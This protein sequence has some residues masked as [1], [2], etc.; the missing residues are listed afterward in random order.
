M[1]N[2]G[3]MSRDTHEWLSSLAQSGAEVR[4]NPSF[5]AAAALALAEA[6]LRAGNVPLAQ[7]WI[8]RARS[9]LATGEST[10]VLLARAY[11]TCLAG[12]AELLSSD[13]EQALRALERGQQEM[14]TVLGADHPQG[15]LLSVNKALALERM[16]R[17]AEALEVVSQVES[18]LRAAL[19]P[20][21]PLFV[22]VVRLRERLDSPATRSPAAVTAGDA[23]RRVQSPSVRAEF[24]N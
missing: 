2:A 3:E 13:P 9:I 7:T 15:L 11:A 20:T 10:S 6:A 8:G 23:S 14:S 22:R 1:R 21:A 12:I 18:P 5:K 24:F 19:G 4:I 16:G 17:R